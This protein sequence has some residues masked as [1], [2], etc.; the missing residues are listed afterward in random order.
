MKPYE[1]LNETIKFA[2]KQLDD[3]KELGKFKKAEDL[4]DVSTMVITA[5][6]RKIIEL[7]EGVRVSGANGLKGSAELNYR[8]LVEAYLSLEFIID[9]ESLLEN[10]AKAYKI[11]YH[12]QQIQSVERAKNNVELPPG[13]EMYLD[14]AVKY[15]K[16]AMEIEEMQDVLAKY[17][18]LHEKDNRGYLPKWH[19]LYEGVNSFNA[20]AKKLVDEDMEED[21][22]ADLYSNMSV[23]A[24]N[25][26][27][28]NSL[29]KEGDNLSIKPVRARFNLN[30]DEY[31]FV[32]TRALLLSTI[33]NFT[34]LK[35]TDYE[36]QLIV[37]LEHIKPHLNLE[38]K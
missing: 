37:F 24:H 28:L 27:T 11:G 4:N 30:K 34:K 38:G 31:N 13:K 26:M 1:V 8:G 35:Y 19:S 21:L 32:G 18:I 6:Y 10:R 16:E 5:L 25:Y 2:T 9:D 23:Q 20:L 14:Q 33:T 15:H 7:S 12:K 36:K 29:F 3:F 22:M 17:N